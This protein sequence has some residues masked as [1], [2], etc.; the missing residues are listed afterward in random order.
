M[1]EPETPA[2]IPALERA[3]HLVALWVERAFTYPRLTQAE[4]HVLAFLARHAPCSINDLHRHF[5]H[6]RSTLTSLLDRLEARGWVRRAPHP[7]SR[8]LVQLTLTETGRP[9]AERVS[10]ATRALE[11][12]VLAHSS[13]EEMT[14]FLHVIQALEEAAR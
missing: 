14:A 3:T 2:I 7:T 12:Q 10:A 9:V 4:A 1:N 5:G 6:R 13:P 11:A 8:R